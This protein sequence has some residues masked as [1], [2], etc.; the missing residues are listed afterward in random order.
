MNLF[1]IH[2]Y[3]VSPQRL[4][5]T[6]IPPRG[7]AFS[8]DAAF[9]KALDEYVTKSK[10]E[11]QPTVDFRIKP[12]DRKDPNPQHEVRSLIIS[13]TFGA[14][15]TAKSAALSLARRLGN[16]MDDRSPFTLLLLSAYKNAASQ[17]L[18]IWAFLKD[19][20]FHFSAHGDR[21]KFKI[22]KDAFSRSSSFKKAALF[23]GIDSPA[24]FLSGR[25]IDKQSQ[26]GYGT[27]ADYWVSTFLD[28]RFSRT[29]TAGTQLLAKCLREAYDALEQ[30]ADRD[31]ISHAIVGAHASR[32]R[33]WSLQGFAREYLDGAA[34]SAFLNHA[35]QEARNSTFEF[36]K[37]EFEKKLNFHIYRLEDDVVVSAPFGATSVKVPKQPAGIF[38][39][40][41]IPG[42]VLDSQTYL[43]D[44]RPAAQF[45]RHLIIR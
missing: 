31:Q 17:R 36:H 14:T 28:S 15:A 40:Y 24:H 20:P 2:A 23:E 45:T 34:K 44:A 30:Q 21:A 26:N 12:S 39:D 6:A 3:E 5:E 19:E 38:S 27:A 7:G 42:A 9:I 18:V 35:P 10:L 29:G 11:S 37:D 13:Y 25:V 4:S 43:V 16:S 32:R 1:R 41:E 22:L 8:A 33:Q